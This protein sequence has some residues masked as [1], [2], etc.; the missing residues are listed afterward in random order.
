[1]RREVE[2]TALAAIPQRSEL[3]FANQD[4]QTAYEQLA[5]LN[6]EIAGLEKRKQDAEKSIEGSGGQIAEAKAKALRK[7]LRKKQRELNTLIINLKKQH[8]DIAAMWGKAPTELSQLSGQLNPRTGIVQYLILDEKSYAFVVRHDGSVEIEPL[9]LYGR[10]VGYQCP[11]LEESVKEYDCFDLKHK[12]NRYRALLVG[13]GRFNEGWREWEKAEELEQLGTELSNLLL[14]PVA[15]HIKGLT[16]LILVPNGILHRLPFAALPWNEGY[17]IEYAKLTLLPASSLVGALLAGP[18]DDLKGLLAL[19]NSVP[20]ETYWS[21]LE[22]AEA[23]VKALPKYFPDLRRER[24]HI[25]IGDDATLSFL[26]DKDLEGYLIHIA[27][28]A[29]S[30]NNAG[31]ARLLLTGGD[32]TY[33]DAVGLQIK[34]APLVVLSGCETGLGERLSGDEVYSLANAFLLAQ[35]R[36]V[37]FSLWLLNDPAAKALMDEFY[38]NF[39]EGA[40]AAALAEAQRAMIRKDSPPAHWAGFVISEWSNARS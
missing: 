28:H 6:N 40:A 8:K 25:L 1:M 30:G 15:E 35:A 5:S 12:V 11:Q 2:R 31:E 24:K 4:K 21:N 27:T 3:K 33:E 32:L 29:E 23:E 7:E 34:N 26:L 16:H 13:T 39:R 10:D 36:S 17:L 19:G 20:E 18:A 38:G 14:S 9:Q 37:I 22:W